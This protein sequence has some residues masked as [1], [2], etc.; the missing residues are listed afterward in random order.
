M[1]ARTVEV[2]VHRQLEKILLFVSVTLIGFVVASVVFANDPS[3][4]TFREVTL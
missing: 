2:F 4:P 3:C 1:S